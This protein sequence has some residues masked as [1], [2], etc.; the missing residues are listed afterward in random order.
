MELHLM[1]GITNRLL[2]ELDTRLQATNDCSVRIDDWLARLG[3]QR[4]PQH[5]RQINGNDCAKVLESVDQLEQMV[6]DCDACLGMPVVFALRCFREVKRTCFSLELRDGFETAVAHFAQA[7]AD[8]GISTTP[9]VHALIDHVVPFLSSADNREARHGL[10][11]WS[12]QAG[13]AVH[14]DFNSLWC[15]SYKYAQQ[16]LKCTVAYCSRHFSASSASEALLMSLK[17]RRIRAYL[18]SKA[19]QFMC[20]L[21]QL[22]SERN[23]SVLAADVHYGFLINLCCLLSFSGTSHSGLGLLSKCFQSAEWAMTLCGLGPDWTSLAQASRAADIPDAWSATAAP[24]A[25]AA[26]A[27]GAT[28]TASAAADCGH[29][30]L[31]GHTVECAARQLA[32][33]ADADDA[34]D[35]AARLPAQLLLD[36]NT[37]NSERAGGGSGGGSGGSEDANELVQKLEKL[38]QCLAVT[39]APASA[40]QFTCHQA[41]EQPSRIADLLL[42]W[43]RSAEAAA[44]AAAAAAEAALP[45]SHAT[46]FSRRLTAAAAV[47]TPAADTDGAAGA[48]P[49]AAAATTYEGLDSALHPL[50]GPHSLLLAFAHIV[51]CCD[52]ES[53]QADALDLLLTS[54]RRSP[55]LGAA[56]NRAAGFAMLARALAHPRCQLGRRGLALLLNAAASETVALPDCGGAIVSGHSAVLRCPPLVRDVLLC[57]DLWDRLSDELLDLLLDG[58]LSFLAP[59]NPHRLLN[60]NR[61][62]RLGTVRSLLFAC[63]DR[64]LSGGLGGGSGGSGGRLPSGRAVD[65]LAALLSACI[66]RPASFPDLACLCNCV[67]LLHPPASTYVCFDANKFY[68]SLRPYD[69]DGGVAD[70]PSFG[71]RPEQQQQQQQPD[72]SPPAAAIIEESQQQQQ[73]QQKQKKKEKQKSSKSSTLVSDRAAQGDSAAPH[74]LLGALIGLVTEIVRGL[75]DTQLEQVLS[76]GLSLESI[77]ALAL[78][79]SAEV[80]VRVAQ[81]FAVYATRAAQ[82]RSLSSRLADLKAFVLTGNQLRQFPA[83]QQLWSVA[84][85][86]VLGS[87]APVPVDQPCEALAAFWKRP[88]TSLQRRSVPLLLSL[89]EQSAH[90]GRMFYYGALIRQLLHNSGPEWTGLMIESG[91]VEAIVN[92]LCAFYSG[93]AVPA[94]A[95]TSS[96]DE[97]ADADDA[98]DVESANFSLRVLGEVELAMASVAAHLFYSPDPMHSRLFDDLLRLFASL[99]ARMIG[100]HGCASEAGEAPR[101]VL[102]HMLLAVLHRL[103]ASSGRPAAELMPFEQ[104]LAGKRSSLQLAES[105]NPLQ[106]VESQKLRDLAAI[107]EAVTA[108][109]ELTLSMTASTS[110]V[111]QQQ[112]QQFTASGVTN[113]VDMQ[114]STSAASA[115]LLSFGGGSGGV[116]GGGSVSETGRTAELSARL[117]RLLPA[118]IDTLILLPPLEGRLTHSVRLAAVFE[119]SVFELLL[120]GLSECLAKR[121]P[122]Q[123]HQLMLQ[124]RDVL[125]VQL[126]RLLVHLVSPASAPEQRLF[127]VH[128][129][130][131]ENRARDL[132]RLCCLASGQAV[133]SADWGPAAGLSNLYGL[134]SDMLG[135]PDLQYS[136]VRDDL[137]NLNLL[138]VLREAEPS[139]PGRC[140]RLAAPGQAEAAQAVSASRPR[141]VRLEAWMARLRAEAGKLSHLAMDVT[142]LVVAAQN[143]QR[144]RLLDD[145]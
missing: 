41:A 44:A 12:E 45:T 50:G 122:V 124:S 72:S 2:E 116:G 39:Y 46:E 5:G 104:Q 61:L 107:A 125:K 93:A 52:S 91:L 48:S 35:D 47:T 54:V 59:A 136:S 87:S 14:R 64:V 56:F 13:E 86:L 40:A 90:S 92:G 89:L 126:Y 25:T 133:A 49:L 108:S 121:R 99:D 111:T 85:G 27:A 94:A 145:M 101:H 114:S 120:R 6:R 63:A 79:P 103:F 38:R 53:A 23:G 33:S 131:A 1:L 9:K 76:H 71:E 77:L 58:L 37:H 113:P 130:A 112:Q 29:R 117:R 118:V 98:D 115:S 22:L 127:A 18:R 75:A 11:F 19:M 139:P 110:S 82:A 57:W 129:L 141:P 51:G 65:R 142:R 84:A 96:A 55:S 83:S 100:R 21:L 16:L 26:S 144:K 102:L 24:T 140:Q 73:L 135:L 74:R 62:Q 67:L 97:S 43:R 8:L 4:Q 20:G 137:V 68:F 70:S 36:S 17:R 95:S 109:S 31:A 60:A 78:H 10:G 81:L 34:V 69:S 42:G 66:G 132:L 119:R 7:Y 3:V 28:A 30:D 123:W 138:N 88:A 143:A 80:R 32:D 15:R 106:F 105:L 134:L 128:T